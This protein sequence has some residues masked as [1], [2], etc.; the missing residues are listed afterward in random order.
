MF[1]QKYRFNISFN[2]LALFGFI[3]VI[4]IFLP[5]TDE[6][7]NFL[8]DLTFYNYNYKPIKDLVLIIACRNTLFIL[9]TL[10][11]HYLEKQ[12]ILNQLKSNIFNN[13]VI[14]FLQIFGILLIIVP[15]IWALINV[16]I[17]TSFDTMQHLVLMPVIAILAITCIL[18]FLLVK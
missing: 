7:T 17:T 18:I 8:S 14:K 1:F 5:F 13:N 6:F 9:V 16:F 3:S 12:N 10:I 11:A 2:L 15:I 4:W